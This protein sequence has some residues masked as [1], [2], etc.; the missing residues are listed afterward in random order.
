MKK[1]VWVTS[2]FPPRINVATNRNV[3]FIKYLTQYEWEA[4]VVSPKE[5]REHTNASLRLTNQ[6]GETAT[7]LSMPSDPF[8][9]LHDKAEVNKMARYAAH[10]MNNIVPPDGHI[11]W[12]MLVLGRIGKEI[13]R[14]EPDLVYTTCSPF[15]INLIGAWIKYRY[16]IPWVTDFRDLWTLNPDRRRF[17]SGYHSII[18]GILEKKYL[19][20]CD[21]LIANT[22]ASE[23]RMVE[24]YPSLKNKTFVIPNGFD[25]M[26]IPP[27]NL[28]TTEGAFFYGGLIDCTNNYTPF[29]IL[30]LLG[31]LDNK[32]MMNNRWTVHYAGNEGEEF[33]Q[34]C[35]QA[36]IEGRENTY[37]YLDHGNFYR[38]IQ[39]MSYVIMCMPGDVDTSSWIPA[40]L[41]DYMGN[42]S[43]II[44]LAARDSELARVIQ[45]YGSGITLFYD[46][47][48]DL[49]IQK[50]HA[51]LIAHPDENLVSDEFV[52]RFSRKNLTRQLCQAF[53]HIT[54][55]RLR[56]NG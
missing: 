3:K 54:S 5:T 42:R 53:N 19:D 48:E 25:P 49:Q 9:L 20:Y 22:N 46:E 51:F 32:G 31:K 38:L 26:D 35:R 56:L 27:R 2:F 45:E 29:P 12:C 15:S 30:R 55:N 41:Y 47:P 10:L 13:E 6:V 8:L 17:L 43:R 44:C 52:E 28:P 4:L 18:S 11:F 40:R 14:Y 24:K 33:S 39:S 21:A 1:V 23:S 50:L 36:G 7:I 34:L 37:G 16:R